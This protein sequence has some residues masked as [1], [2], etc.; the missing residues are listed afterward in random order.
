M[1]HALH[2]VLLANPINRQ[3]AIIANQ[4]GCEDE[5]GFLT[6]QELVDLIRRLVRK[7]RLLKHILGVRSKAQHTNLRYKYNK[8]RTQY[9]QQQDPRAFTEYIRC[10]NEILR[11][12]RELAIDRKCRQLAAT[13]RT[14]PTTPHGL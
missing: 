13:A 2:K 5:K 4:S 9:R 11:L 14:I 8:K 1:A 10:G 12:N 3:S 7:H 6:R